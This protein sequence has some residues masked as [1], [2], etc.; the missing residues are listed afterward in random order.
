M[1]NK[2]AAAVLV[3]YSQHIAHYAAIADVPLERQTILTKA[4]REHA[5]RL[6]SK[7][8]QV[9]EAAKESDMCWLL[10]EKEERPKESYRLHSMAKSEDRNFIEAKLELAQMLKDIRATERKDPTGKKRQAERDKAA[11]QRAESDARHE[12]E[13][14]ELA[15]QRREERKAEKLALAAAEAAAATK[16]AKQSARK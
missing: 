10:L 1:V 12:L 13:K 2:E 16:K 7:L 4:A 6:L 11:K 8:I 9:A 5:W 3:E 14:K 15:R